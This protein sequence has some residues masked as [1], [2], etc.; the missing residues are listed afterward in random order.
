MLFLFKSNQGYLSAQLK[1]ISCNTALAAWKL[2]LFI[3]NLRLAPSLEIVLIA[4]HVRLGNLQ[5]RATFTEVNFK[6][7][8]VV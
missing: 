3:W 5:L 6:D 8:T 7:I 1:A 4:D 2:T